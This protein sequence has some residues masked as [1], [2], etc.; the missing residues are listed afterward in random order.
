M[1]DDLVCPC[2]RGLSYTTCCQ[3]IIDDHRAATTAEQL[4]RSR[5]SAFA[6]KKSPH[7]QASWHPKTRPKILN[8]DDHPVQWLGLE[9]HT[10]QD[11]QANDTSGSVEFTSSYL[12]N[13]QL[14]RLR[15]ISQFVMEDKRWYYL[16][17]ECQVQKEKVERNRPCPCGS[18]KKFKR[19][20]LSR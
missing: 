14:C 6:L 15:E 4:M 13:G 9:I 3:P 8:F 1:K 2:G 18:G 5:Y 16:R 10:C 12:E 17:G 19:C 11:G 7:I 20:C